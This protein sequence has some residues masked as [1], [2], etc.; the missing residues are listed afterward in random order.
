[1]VRRRFFLSLLLAL[2]LLLSALGSLRDITT[3]LGYWALWGV[4]ALAVV[5]A[6]WP[7]FGVYWERTIPPTWVWGSF[8]I[9]VLG[10]GLSAAVNHSVL[11]LHHGVKIAVIGVCCCIAW[12][13]AAGLCWRDR[14]FI[15]R[16]V[17]VSVV[18]VF[19]A[20][21]AAPYGY[22]IDLGSAGREGSFLAWPGVIWKVGAFFLPMFL[23]DMLIRPR[24]WLANGLAI[25]ACVFLVMIDGTRTGILVLGMTVLAFG[26]ILAWRRDWS[27][28]AMARPAI[29]TFV[30]ALC[31]LLLL[32]AGVGYLS[33]GS[34]AGLSTSRL[35]GAGGVY[36]G[37]AGALVETAARPITT[38]RL[39]DGDPE[40]LKLLEN[41][42]ERAVGCLPMGCGFGSTFIDPGYGVS[43]PVHNA[44][45]GALADFGVLGFV[46]MLGFIV[47]A[48]VAIR[49]VLRD[50]V[51]GAEDVYFV[52]ASAG[53][54]LA[55][56]AS[57]LLH[58]FSSEMS[59][60]GY[61][62]LM[63]AFAWLPGEACKVSVSP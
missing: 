54:A 26:G 22:Y 49:R 36:M 16:W 13:L 46:G 38:T 20:S 58:T 50:Q 44:Y 8:M 28:L 7:V 40:R 31:G 37:K 47:A 27:A 42:A 15:L 45:L 9:L 48:M 5:S 6:T 4:W 62:I 23:A 33:H 19:L 55:Y 63:L 25:A 30:P 17:L 56:L 52:L 3:P 24:D 51:V 12:R 18:L 1:M 35:A 43:M 53:A 60:W 57:L 29:V 39:G 59:E 34:G 61:L 14:V 11:S 41:G 2:S 32:S 10:M 21:K